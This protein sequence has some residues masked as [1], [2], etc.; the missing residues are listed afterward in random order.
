MPNMKSVIQNYNAN[1]ISKHTTAVAARSCSCRQK[2][3]CLLNN[4]CLSKSLVYK[5]AVSLTRSQVNKYY[6]GTC[7]KTFKE[8]YNNHTATIRNK[9]K[10]KS[11]EVTKHIWA[12]KGNSIQ[13]QISWDIGSRACP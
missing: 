6:Y 8:R 4:K 1:L 3:E 13:Y 9:N 11:T 7:G 5:E 2:S 12:V 10:Q